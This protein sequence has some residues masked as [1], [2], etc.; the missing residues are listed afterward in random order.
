MG[1]IVESLT[2]TLL[3]CT[4]L[5]PEHGKGTYCVS[6]NNLYLIENG[7][8]QLKVWLGHFYHFLG[9]GGLM[10]YVNGFCETPP[11]KVTKKSLQI[12]KNIY[13]LDIFFISIFY[14]TLKQYLIHPTCCWR[15]STLSP[16][17]DIIFY[18]RHIV[19]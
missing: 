3:K 19:R 7:G 5:L 16:H 2:E 15:G 14:I 12:F 18:S 11:Q 4:V 6:H 17:F 9:G 13:L 1:N 8:R 10:I